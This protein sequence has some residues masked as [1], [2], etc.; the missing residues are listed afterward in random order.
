MREAVQAR[1]GR[2]TCA[3]TSLE[4]VTAGPLED[5]A[6]ARDGDLRG[7]PP[8]TQR[9]QR[10]DRQWLASPQVC[11]LAPPASSNLTRVRHTLS[12]QGFPLRIVE[13]LLPKSP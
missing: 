4:T 1:Q 12:R 3:P 10:F 7:E 11:E 13:H 9:G 6:P 8:R 2:A 5:A